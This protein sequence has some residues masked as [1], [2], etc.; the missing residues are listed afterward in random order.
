MRNC[1]NSLGVN[2]WNFCS[3]VPAVTASLVEII[4]TN[5]ASTH[6]IS[7]LRPDRLHPALAAFL[8]RLESKR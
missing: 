5:T 6:P 3:K 2:L 4:C 1:Y 8:N 7:A